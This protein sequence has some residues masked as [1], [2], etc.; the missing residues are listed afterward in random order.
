MLKSVDLSDYIHRGPIKV[1]D[2]D[3]LFEA[4]DT[5]TRNHISGVLVIDRNENLVGV[6]SELDCLR[7]VVTATYNNSADIGT[8][9]DYMT[10]EVQS[11]QLHDNIVDVAMDMIAKGHRRRPVLDGERLVGQLTCRQLLRVVRQFNLR[12]R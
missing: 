7:A 11:C 9:A 3:P 4:I 12:D 1:F 2:T 10:S 6:L 8:V 5:I